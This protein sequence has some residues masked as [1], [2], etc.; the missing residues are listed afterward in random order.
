MIFLIEVPSQISSYLKCMLHSQDYIRLTAEAICSKI[1]SHNFLLPHNLPVLFSVAGAV[2]DLRIIPIIF[3]FMNR[4]NI[5]LK[6][7]N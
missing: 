6:R 5:F 7:L 3:F 2:I 1:F 4:Y